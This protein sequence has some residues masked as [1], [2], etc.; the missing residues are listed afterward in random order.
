[1]P[2]SSHKHGIECILNSEKNKHYSHLL[3]S[4]KTFLAS[5]DN[6]SR[7]CHL[8]PGYAIIPPRSY[9]EFDRYW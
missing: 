4:I 3:G 6:R 9:D 8:S 5:I 7:F 1:M 2:T